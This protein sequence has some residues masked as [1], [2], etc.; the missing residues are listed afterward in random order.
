MNSQKIKGTQYAVLIRAIQNGGKV[1]EREDRLPRNSSSACFRLLDKGFLRMVSDSS[2]CNALFE[3]TFTTWKCGPD[4][5]I[6]GQ[7]A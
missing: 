4:W 1:R 5:I 3:I 6:P 7:P 2:F